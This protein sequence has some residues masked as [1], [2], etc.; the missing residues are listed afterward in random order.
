LKRF[1]SLLKYGSLL[2][3]GLLL[4]WLAL[5]NQNQHKIYEAFKGARYSYLF[6]SVFFMILSDI[7]RSMRWTML[8]KPLGYRVSTFNSFIAVMIGYLANLGLPRV[9]EFTRCMILKRTDDIPMDRLVGTV[10]VERALDLLVLLSVVGLTLIL[11]F[12]DISHFYIHVLRPS[13]AQMVKP[14]L[15]IEPFV[16]VILGV[17]VL[18]LIF[19]GIHVRYGKTAYVEKIREILKGVVSGLKTIRLLDRPWLFWGHTAFI[20]IMYWAMTYIVFFSL[21]ATS[22]LDPVAG[23]SVFAI[24]SVGFIMPVQGGIGTYH[25]AVTE[26]L[27]IYGVDPSYGFTYATL[28]H[29]SQLIATL[30]IGGLSLLVFF[31]YRKRKKEKEESLQTDQ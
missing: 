11:E 2:A 7:S 16:V 18:G 6:I 15:D 9:G 24:G 30:I 28:V 10:F 29:G 27:Q 20:W 5:R 25:W 4:F 23:L 26:G 17:L 14:Y 19:F 21:D 12:N 3:T 8:I 22:H 31:L 1:K 13:I